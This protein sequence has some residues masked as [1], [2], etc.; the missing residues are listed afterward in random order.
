MEVY[1]R[2]SSLYFLGK[3]VVESYRRSASADFLVWELALSSISTN[4]LDN[5]NDDYSGSLRGGVS[6]EGS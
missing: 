1:R 5:P 2:S 4:D 3:A 6:L